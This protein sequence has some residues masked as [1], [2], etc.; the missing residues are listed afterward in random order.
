MKH[1]SWPGVMVVAASTILSW[2]AGSP[3]LSPAGHARAAIALGARGDNVEGHVILPTWPTA[4]TAASAMTAMQVHDWNARPPTRGRPERDIFAFRPGTIMLAPSPAPAGPL[5]E[6]AGQGHQP[7][8][9]RLKLIGVAEDAGP[10]GTIRT[11][12]I[13]G[14]GQLYLAKEGETVASIYRVGTMSSDSVELIDS[15]G[16]PGVRLLLQ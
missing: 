10:E 15:T 2:L 1:F 7:S 4:A 11:A 12:I 5:L 14:Q 13:S 16:G 3:A 9:V 6:A 8:L